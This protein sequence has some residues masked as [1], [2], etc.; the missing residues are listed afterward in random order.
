MTVDARTTSDDLATRLRHDAWRLLFEDPARLRTDL[1][2][3]IRS[4][5]DALPL[6]Q[7]FRA[8][9]IDVIGADLL[10]DIPGAPLAR[11]GDEPSPG[12]RRL[13]GLIEHRRAG[14]AAAALHHID[15]ALSDPEPPL[16]LSRAIVEE[17]RA[18][19]HLA[20]G[21]TTAALSA[22][23]A[24]G[25]HAA[26][27]PTLA[28]RIQFESAVAHALR[29]NLR[30]ARHYLAVGEAIP[31]AAP[32]G[33]VTGEWR[34]VA[35]GLIAVESVSHPQLTAGLH[36]PPIES[37]TDLW[38]LVA[39]VRGREAL[40]ARAPLRA[41]E[42]A[43]FALD[44]HDA[45]TPFAASAMTWLMVS[46]LVDLDDAPRAHAVVATAPPTTLVD[47]ARARLALHENARADALRITG[48]VLARAG[49]AMAERGEALLL[50]LWAVAL[51]D[52]LDPRE[53]TIAARLATFSSLRRLF[54]L[55]PTWLI[56]QIAAALDEPSRERMS[57]AT[58]DL[59]PYRPM[60]ATPPVLTTRESAVLQ[61][62]FTF[63]SISQIAAAMFVTPSTVKSQLSS[64]YRK[65]GAR[66][67]AEAMAIATRLDLIDL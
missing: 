19:V 62:L 42:T 18:L 54:A 29:G 34:D 66:G 32:A 9:A 33:A 25:A 21:E 50:R 36:L 30:D 38:P 20:S 41:L 15:T 52:E 63:D 11:A 35:R 13:R 27:A 43:E 51:G 10:Y 1:A 55:V 22:L 64:V 28:Q 49:T 17:Q 57:R 26:A 24:A 7:G 46:A 8:L 45:T 4:Q 23:A 3:L 5:P 59:A 58:V 14:D 47:L 65:L 2:A 37:A 67:R 40:V 16:P 60:T 12:I 48:A 39:L 61:A 31:V 44:C 6:A 56:A 53:C